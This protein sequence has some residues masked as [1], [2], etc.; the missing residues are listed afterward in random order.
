MRRIVVL[1]LI[2]IAATAHAQTLRVFN[3]AATVD[4][5]I[6]PTI[7]EG[8]ERFTGGG[9]DGLSNACQ[10]GID[11]DIQ[12]SGRN[13]MTVSC[14][15][16]IPSFG[17]VNQA[18][19]ADA[20]RGKRV[21]YS[22]MVRAENIADIQEEQGIGGLWLRVEDNNPAIAIMT[23]NMRDRG[24]RGSVEWIQVE[25][26]ADIPENA[27]R[28]LIG[29]WMQGQGQLWISDIRFEEVGPNVPVTVQ[30]TVRQSGPQN[31][32]LSQ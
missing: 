12:G 29:F 13:N 4:P 9:P 17:G 24:I 16:G 8:W 20:F 14:L 18:F 19:P 22:A 26:V 27:G 31:V 3:S 21:R 32:T 2:L 23:D 6:D 30:P 1:A 7:P 15:R 10:A 25:S 11:L 28:I 5:R